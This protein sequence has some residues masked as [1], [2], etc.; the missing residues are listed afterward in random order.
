MKW[1]RWISVIWNVFVEFD[2]IWSDKSEQMN[3]V[4]SEDPDHW[5]NIEQYLN[6]NK[7]NHLMIV[8]INDDQHR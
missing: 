5:S 7:Y 4:F 3:I 1:V 6:I 2:E 8:G